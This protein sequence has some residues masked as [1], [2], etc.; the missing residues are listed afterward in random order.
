MISLLLSCSAERDLRL[1]DDLI[2]AGE[3]H[4][5]ELPG[6][7]TAAPDSPLLLAYDW[8]PNVR[9]ELESLIRTYGR[10]DLPVDGR[11]VAVFDFDN[12]CIRHD[13]GHALL[14]ELIERRAFQTSD[15]FWRHIPIE[16]GRAELQAALE[17]LEELGDDT[18]R[19]VLEA[20]PDFRTWRKGM[21]EVYEGVQ[22]REGVDASVA[23]LVQVMSGLRPRD[24]RAYARLALERQLHTAIEVR[25][26]TY[27]DDDPEPLPLEYGIR[28]YREIRDLVGALQRHGFD[29]WVVSASSQSAVEVAAQ[30]LGIATDRVIGVR[31]ALDAEGRL[32]DEIVAPLPNGLGKL[33]AI[34]AY[35]GRRPLLVFGD[36]LNDRDMLAAARDVAVLVDRGRADIRKV[37]EEKG[38]LIQPEFNLDDGPGEGQRPTVRS[39]ASPEFE[40]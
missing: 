4:S 6:L 40:G 35:I 9:A 11:P 37:A 10:P 30:G 20:N 15:T 5:V 31:A 33:D 16:L 34:D 2:P 19:E 38:W 21:F 17:R 1:P 25:E 18:P 14:L 32:I 27:D 39:G 29:V 13:I 28:Y 7:V 3:R 26:L 12:T 22:R 24:I 36:S 23:W 8:L